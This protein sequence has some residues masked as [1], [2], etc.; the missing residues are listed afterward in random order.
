MFIGEFQISPERPETCVLQQGSE[1]RYPPGL[2]EIL[3]FPRIDGISN[4]KGRDPSTFSHQ[5]K[6]FLLDISGGIYS[7]PGEFRVMGLVA[8]SNR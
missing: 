6:K 7:M 5:K 1:I 8:A 4:K 2:E 3:V